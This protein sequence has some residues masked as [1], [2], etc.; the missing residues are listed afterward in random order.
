RDRDE[1]VELLTGVARLHARGVKVD[2][3]AYF[4]GTAARTTDLPTYAFQRKPYWYDFAAEASSFRQPSDA[5]DLRYQIAWDRIAEAEG[6]GPS[7]PWI[8][9]APDGRGWD[10]PVAA[11]TGAL[12]R[13]GAEVALVKGA[14][15]DRDALAQRLRSAVGG[16]AGV[17]SL[18]ALDDRPLE[19]HPELSRG[20]AATLLLVQALDEA[21]IA[22]PLWCATTGAVAVHG[23][24]EVTSPRQAALW[25]LGIGLSL[26]QPDAWGG[27][28]D[29]PGEVDDTAARRLCHVL[30]A[31]PGGEDQVAVRPDGVH[32]RRLVRAPLAAA[33]AP[34]RPAPDPAR[35]ADDA[36]NGTVLITGGTGGL[37]A[38]VARMMA[39]DGTGHL[40]LTSRSGRAAEG[41]DALCAELE[42]LGSRVT[43][44]ACDVAD[45]DALERLIGGIAEDRPLTTVVHAAG[46]AQSPG[47][48]TAMSLGE[49]AEV[50]RA[51]VL[52]AAHLDEL[53][54]DRPL[55]AFVLFS[56]GAGVWGSAGQAAYGSANAY[57]DG[58]AHH[59]R[60]RGLAATSIAWGSWDAGMVDAKVSAMGRRIGAPAMSPRR[61]VGALREVLG[62]GEG[63]VVVAD[64]DWPRFAPTY[65]L[66]RP[67][68]LLDALPEARAALAGDDDTAGAE[69]SGLVGRLAAMSPADQERTLLDLVRTHVAELLGYDA[70]G[71]VDATRAFDDLGFDSV[72]A[73]DLRSRL[74]KSVGRKLPATMVFD[75]ASPTALAGF[76]R[77]E[78]CQDGDTGELPALAALDRLETTVA[79]LAPEEIE[80]MGISGRLQALLGRLTGSDGELGGDVSDQ[81]QSASADDVF[82]FIDKELGLT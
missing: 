36:R 75:F 28:V 7:G 73:V 5:D 82:D 67:R 10:A 46:A 32:A 27:L 57:L 18:L 48:L 68:P 4:A 16:P 1:A 15:E 6:S 26:D 35:P 8:V 54:G 77:A 47:P 29:L 50:A 52:G 53:L 40:L 38:H 59:R 43:V 65:A 69:D 31:R 42:A 55:D 71:A 80:R 64:F 20:T 51:K 66:A 49:L 12:T 39:A 9:V 41:V 33:P 79:A 14:G 21:G 76:L 70:P 25:G 61:A 72:A 37:G 45:R 44:A 60:A 56:S 30:A 3:R 62:R 2:W 23:S 34:R 24:A 58:L 19:L 78:L 74:T 11:L 13:C 22:A 17:L 81:L 63:H